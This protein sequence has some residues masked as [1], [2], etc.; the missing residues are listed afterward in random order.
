[1]KVN[2]AKELEQNQTILAIVPSDKYNNICVNDVKALAKKGPVCYVTLNKTADALKEDFKKH[3]VNMEDVVFIDAISKTIKKVPDQADQ[4]YYV[5]SP[6]SLTELSIAIEKFV[7]HEFS[8]LIIDSLTN[9]LVYQKK[10]P[11]AKFISSLMNKIKQTKTKTLL[12]AI[13][14]KNQEDL[15]KQSETFVDKVISLT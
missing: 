13:F 6:S 12:Y 14:V 8:F 15:I 2:I 3:K 7:K 1:M 11:V 9:F 5:S 10:A 4:I